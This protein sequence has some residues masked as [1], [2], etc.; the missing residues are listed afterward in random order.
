VVIRWLHATS[1]NAIA[2]S[3]HTAAAFD[4]RTTQVIHNAVDLVRFSPDQADGARFRAELGIPEDSVLMCVVGQL[5]KWKGQDDAIRVLERVRR[6]HPDARLA[7]VGEP[8]FVAPTTRHDNRAF[9]GELR[10]LANRVGGVHFTGERDDVPDIMAA[11]DLVL[12][13]SWEEPFGRTVVEAM[14]LGRCVV[15]TAVGGP[16]EVITDGVDGRLLEPRDPQ[17]WGEVASEL[18]ADPESR[19][20]LG[21]SARDRARSFD[22]ASH[23]RRIAGIYAATGIRRAKRAAAGA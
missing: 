19:R 6:D 9:E 20:R 4:A 1:R 16:A 15:A 12:A 14:A 8:K 7:I 18:L 22:R 21:N 10:E 2:I 3:T 11:S 5:T 13:P 23:A 17:T